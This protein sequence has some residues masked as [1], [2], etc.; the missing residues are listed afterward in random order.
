MH[1]TE[2]RDH[3]SNAIP[4]ATV[5]VTVEPTVM[6]PADNPFVL[7]LIVMSALIEL[8]LVLMIELLPKN[9]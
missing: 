4:F 3:S 2:I 8:P 6:G 9:G 7:L 1:T 5:T